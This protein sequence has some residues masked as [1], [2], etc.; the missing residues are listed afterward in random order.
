MDTTQ[1]Q[2]EVFEKFHFGKFHFY[3]FFIL[4]E[5][6]GFHFLFNFHKNEIFGFFFIKTANPD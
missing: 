3:F 2:L 6:F 1:F 4:L 5:V